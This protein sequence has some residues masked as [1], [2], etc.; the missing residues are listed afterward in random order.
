M[1]E[2]SLFVKFTF[3]VPK[4]TSVK[5]WNRDWQGVGGPTLLRNFHL[6]KEE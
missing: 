2:S 5:E 6:E 4:L 1:S 3:F